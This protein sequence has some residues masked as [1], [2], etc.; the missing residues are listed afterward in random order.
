M[1]RLDNA[2]NT[3]P[4][5]D[6]FAKS[7]ALTESRIVYVG[8]VDSSCKLKYCNFRE[9]AKLHLD[10]EVIRN[11]MAITSSMVVAPLEKLE[12]ILGRMSTVLVRFE[13]RVLIFIR[14]KNYS[15]IVGLDPGVPTPFPEYIAGLVKNSVNRTLANQ[16]FDPFQNNE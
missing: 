7:L 14:L 3:G 16:E 5:F 6:G 13:N 12:P 1:N 11:L 9:D 10:D 2:V 15:I 8:I 4:D